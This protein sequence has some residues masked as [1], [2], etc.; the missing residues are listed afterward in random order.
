MTW[1]WELSRRF[2]WYHSWAVMLMFGGVLLAASVPLADDTC[3]VTIF[4]ESPCGT[5]VAPVLGAGL[6]AIGVLAGVLTWRARQR[7]P[8][9]P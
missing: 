2:R 1:G 8:D 3:A 7:A 4:R 9:S 6:L 5:I